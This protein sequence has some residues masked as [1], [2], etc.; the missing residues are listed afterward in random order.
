MSL[1]L[2]YYH[3]K[4]KKMKLNYK[5]VLTAATLMLV[6]ANANANMI[7]DIYAGGT[8]GLGGQSVYLDDDHHKSFSSQSYG[9][10]FGIDLPVVRF[11]AEYDY[12]DSDYVD[13]QILMGNAYVK[14]P[15]LIVVNPYIGV[16]V[17]MLFASDSDAEKY[18]D[19]DTTIAYQGMLG[20]TL[21]IPAIPFKIDI[22]GRALMSTDVY[23]QLHDS[24]MVQYDGRIKLRYIF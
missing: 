4:G 22:E 2:L 24:M 9:A 15:G 13:S 16:G 17:G 14:L 11:E 23:D 3:T 12:I 10:I 1:F 18:N 8:A 5:S 20:A 19:F 7:W 21:N 6:G